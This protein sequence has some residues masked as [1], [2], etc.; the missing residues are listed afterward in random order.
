CDICVVEE[1][2]TTTPSEQKASL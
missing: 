2:E 1:K